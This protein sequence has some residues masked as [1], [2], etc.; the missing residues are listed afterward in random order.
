[1]SVQA[2]RLERI[3]RG[4]LNGQGL[5]PTKT[6][7][8][9]IPYDVAVAANLV[10]LDQNLMPV[11]PMPIKDGIQTFNQKLWG[12]DFLELQRFPCKGVCAHKCLHASKHT[13]SCARQCVYVRMVTFFCVQEIVFG[14]VHTPKMKV[15][16]FT[17]TICQIITEQTVIYGKTLLLLTL[18]LRCVHIPTL[19]LDLMRCRVWVRE[20]RGP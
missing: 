12:P 13:L 7:T 9:R 17:P 5:D 20:V 15:N 2:D 14:T 10:T 8:V 1:M 18:M 4:G 19:T 6:L 16:L 3:Q 11:G